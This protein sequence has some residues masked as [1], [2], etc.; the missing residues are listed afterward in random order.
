MNSRTVSTGKQ[1]AAGIKSPVILYLGLGPVADEHC[2]WLGNAGLSVRHATSIGMLEQVA[3]EGHAAALVVDLSTGDSEIASIDAIVRLKSGLAR[4]PRLIF[5]SDRADQEIRLR[6]IRAGGECF[7]IKPVTPALLMQH[8]EPALLAASHHYRV[9]LI[10]ETS[11]LLSDAVPVLQQ[12]G[13]I[14]KRLD[15]VSQTLLTVINFAPDLIMIEQE[16]SCCRGDQL[17]RMLH[18]LADYEDLPVIYLVPDSPQRADPCTD[19]ASETACPGSVSHHQLV[20]MI[21][22]MAGVA[23]IRKSR[24]HHLQTSDTVTGLQNQHGFLQRMGRSVVVPDSAALVAALVLIEVEDLRE[25]HPQLSPQSVNRLIA[26]FASQLAGLITPVELLA[27]IGDYT[28]ACLIQGRNIDE[29]TQLGEF[30]GHSLSSRILDVGQYSLTLG[31]NIGIAVVHDTLDSGMPLVTLAQ[32]VCKE[33]CLDGGGSHVSIRTLQASGADGQSQDER[34]LLSLLQGAVEKGHFRLVY[35]P[36][37]SLR[38]SV[39]EKYEVLLRLSDDSNR[40]VSP[41]RFIPLAEQHGLMDKIDRWVIQ[42]AIKT[43]GQRGKGASFF[44]KVSPESLGDPGFVRYLKGCLERFSA[45][46]NQLVCELG[47]GGVNAGIRQA[48]AFSRQLAPLG[49]GISIEHCDTSQDIARL[50]EH[51]PAMYVKLGG[52]MIRDLEEDHGRQLQLALVVQQCEARDVQVIAGFVESAACLK[53]L[54]QS[55]VHYIQGNFLQ[56]PDELLGFDFGGDEP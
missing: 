7:L 26:M 12:L 24:I 51:I 47:V 44:V 22:R 27:R 1:G 33:V 2:R 10:A 38:G 54:W 35:Q 39:V 21:D 23:Q 20:N 48:A 43:L 52:D 42:Q 49:C 34:Q 6:A 17:G 11:G 30:L 41:S 5:L 36:I 55:G 4:P 56:E 46:G 15:T 19:H 9:L 53:L 16:L 45:S 8:L 14:I 25:K 29:I 50:L 40:A 13:M 3:R 31:C 37:A 28:F 18:Q 32:Q